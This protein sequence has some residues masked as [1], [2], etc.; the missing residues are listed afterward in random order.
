MA[1]EISTAPALV[2]SSRDTRA[3]TEGFWLDYLA[4]LVTA[5]F[6]MPSELP[7][8][9][10]LLLGATQ[11]RSVLSMVFFGADDVGVQEISSLALASTDFVLRLLRRERTHTAASPCR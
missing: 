7:L 8:T 9:M 11:R 4:S 3:H 1:S 6:L 5:G 2:Q 10:N